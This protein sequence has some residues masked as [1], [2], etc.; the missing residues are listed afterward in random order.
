LSTFLMMGHHWDELGTHRAKLFVGLWVLNMF[1]LPFWYLQ[2]LAPFIVTMVL[3]SWAGVLLLLYWI[4]DA[5]RTSKK[6]AK[7][8]S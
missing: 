8:Q 5:H 2:D 7:P 4:W 6:L 3:W 1:A